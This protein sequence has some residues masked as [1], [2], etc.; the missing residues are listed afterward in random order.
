MLMDSLLTAAFG[1]LAVLAS[2]GKIQLSKD[3]AKN[4]EYLGKYGK[5]LR[6]L[7]IILIV[8]GVALFL[9]GL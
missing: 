9:A 3:S 4:Q 7:G 8:A 2:Y 1:V 6:V 5:L